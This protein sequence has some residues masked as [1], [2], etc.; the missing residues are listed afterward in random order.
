MVLY[1]YDSPT[2][3]HNG[4][5]ANYTTFSSDLRIR[6]R[7]KLDQYQILALSAGSIDDLHSVKL[8]E[9]IWDLKYV[10]GDLI[11]PRT[12]GTPDRKVSHGLEFSVLVNKHP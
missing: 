6:V 8:V 11:D 10:A 12:R 3:K 5:I 4:A 7:S 1:R 2:V 9:S